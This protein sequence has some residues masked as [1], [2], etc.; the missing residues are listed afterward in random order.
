M[1]GEKLSYVSHIKRDD[2]KEEEKHKSVLSID[3]ENSLVQRLGGLRRSSSWRRGGDPACLE[4]AGRRNLGLLASILVH[5]L[6]VVT[7]ELP[8]NLVN[9]FQ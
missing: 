3:F 5:V 1:T 4:P 2:T 8:P 9:V 6:R 7:H